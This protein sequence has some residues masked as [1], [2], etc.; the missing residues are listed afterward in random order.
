MFFARKKMGDSGMRKAQAAIEFMAVFGLMLF[1]FVVMNL[2]VLGSRQAAEEERAGLFAQQLAQE[3]AGKIALVSEAD[4]LAA[5]LLVPAGLGEQSLPF[6]L[7][8]TNS[9]ASV[10]F[11]YSNRQK[12]A[13]AQVRA[14]RVNNGTGAA[15]FNLTEGTYSINNTGGTVFVFK[16]S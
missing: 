15:R 5:Q 6:T 8:I 7:E 2:V 14:T 3:A 10:S 16:T 9:S 4:G 12:G 1:F 13:V 11:Q